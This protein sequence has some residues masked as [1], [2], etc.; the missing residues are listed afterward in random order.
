ME[1]LIVNENEPVILVDGSYFVIHRLFATMKWYKFKNP[2]MDDLAIDQE[3]FMAS[4]LK[5]TRDSIVKIKKKWAAVASGKSRLAKKDWENIP[6]WFAMDSP[7]TEVWR[8]SITKEYKGTREGLSYDFDPMY[9]ISLQEILGKEIPL[10]K[11]KGLEAD[12]VV[13]IT[14]KQLRDKGFEGLIVCITNDNDYLQLMDGKTRLHNLS[15]KDIAERSCGC[16][17]KDLLN[18]II[19][20]DKS[21]NIPAIS[22]RIKPKKLKELQALSVEE[23]IS[24]LQLNEEEKARMEHNRTLVDFSCIPEELTQE[25]LTKYTVTVRKN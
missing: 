14:H 23:I 19:L 1:Q 9:F 12:D 5:H 18:K 2:G 24:S 6:V 22:S 3:E 20:G 7:I 15:D 21:D 17:K 10:M 8:T 4:V 25:C 13:A 11:I 16:P